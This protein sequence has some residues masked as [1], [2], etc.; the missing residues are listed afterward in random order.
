PQ[1]SRDFTNWYGPS[2][3][4]VR[5]RLT[6]NF[7]AELPF[8]KSWIGRDW[9]L[10]G[11]VA[12]RSGRPYTVNQ[13]GHHGGNDNTGLPHVTGDPDSGVDRSCNSSTD[14]AMVTRWFNP[15]AFTAATS[16]S[17]GNEIRNQFRGPAFQSVDLSL[18]RKIQLQSRVGA[19]LRWD[20][21][22]VFN[23]SNFG[24]PNRDAGTP[25]TIGT[26]TSLSGDPRIMQLSL[27]LTF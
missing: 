15:G 6:V 3:Y 27:R 9:T 5:H 10:S 19:V 21:F 26:I 24:L 2:D 18:Q 25:S 16:G 14:C 12:W 4:D 20:I 22:N 7:I 23:R 13:K 17:F 1:N 8:G 11:I